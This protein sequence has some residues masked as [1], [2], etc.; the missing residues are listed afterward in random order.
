MSWSKKGEGELPAWFAG[1]AIGFVI[2]LGFVLAYE[3]GV[4]RG[5]NDTKDAAKAGIEKA[6]IDVAGVKVDTKVEGAAKAEKKPA[7]ASGPGLALFKETCGGCHTLSAASTSGTTGPNLDMIKPD[8]A[9]VLKAI[10][11]GG[12]GSGTMPKNLLTG[13]KAQQVADFLAASDGSQ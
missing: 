11:D 5:T 6:A 3:L 12:A 4:N 13:E 7:A 10:K 1:M 8:S 2:L 9:L